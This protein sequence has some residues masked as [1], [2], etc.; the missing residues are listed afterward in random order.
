MDRKSRQNI[1]RIC[2]AMTR[3]IEDSKLS[4]HQVAMRLRLSPGDEFGTRSL[5]LLYKILNGERKFPHWLWGEWHT[6]TGGTHALTEL[7][8]Q[9][10][11]LFVKTPKTKS[12]DEKALVRCIHEFSEL[13]ERVSESLM[14][15]SEAGEAI[16]DAEYDAIQREA[17]DSIV[18]TLELL[19]KY[20]QRAGRPPQA[21][22]ASLKEAAQLGG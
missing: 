2:S 1:Q 17:F 9:A 14:E 20:N 18:A 11:G 5:S 4:A 7:C 6:V 8:V 19:E 12:G 15:S 10:G 3:D 13:A 22:A 16:S 21:Y